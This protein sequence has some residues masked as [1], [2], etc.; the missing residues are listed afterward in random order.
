[1]APPPTSSPSTGNR[2]R[3]PS[4]ASPILPTSLSP[5]TRRP[6]PART[7]SPP[8]GAV[9]ITAAAAGWAS[10]KI[11]INV[12]QPTLQLSSVTTT[13]TTLDGADNFSVGTYTPNCGPCDFWN[14]DTPIL[15]SLTGSP[16]DIITIN[17]KAPPLTVIGLAN[18]SSVSVSAD[19]ATA[20]GTYTITATASGFGPYTTPTVTVTQPYITLYYDNSSV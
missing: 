18:T 17:G 1:M 13:R 9:T 4:R 15:L 11:T 8:A 10:S 7:P 14:A 3:R 19:Q 12:G 16:S 6:R 2:R 20:P 5:P